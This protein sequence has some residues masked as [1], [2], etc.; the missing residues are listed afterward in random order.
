MFFVVFDSRALTGDTENAATLEVLGFGFTWA[1]WV[2]WQQFDAVLVV[3]EETEP[4]FVENE[5]V[6]G[7]FS[8]GYE[9]LSMACE[10]VKAS[11]PN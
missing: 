9:K 3:Y 6:I 2:E 11:W 1:D 8:E 4:G 10:Q 5:S 7:H